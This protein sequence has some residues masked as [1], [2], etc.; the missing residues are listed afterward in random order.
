MTNHEKSWKHQHGGKRKTRKDKGKKL[1]KEDEY[2]VYKCSKCDYVTDSK[3]KKDNHMLNNHTSS[4]DIPKKAKYYCELCHYGASLRHN[5]ELHKQTKK[6]R[7]M[8]ELE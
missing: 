6:H 4:K 5:Y 3:D 8:E 2:V 1:K 7:K